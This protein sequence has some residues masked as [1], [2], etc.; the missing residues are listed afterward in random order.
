MI[1][2]MT[3]FARESA[4]TDRGVLTVELRSVN[5][6]Y[7]DCSFKL[8]EALRP[9]EPKL[10]EWMGKSLARGKLECFFR[11]QAHP[12]GTGELVVNAERLE[13][14]LEAADLVQRQLAGASPL[15][16]LEILKF[17][18]I[19]ETPEESD[20]ALQGE[21]CD[22][23]RVALK[24]LRK[25]R[26]REGEKLAALLL[27]RLAQVETEVG[28]ARRQLP[29]L[30]QQQRER[31]ISRIEE[32]GIEVDH[33]RLEQEL[34]HL[35][36][37]A[38]VDEE[39]DRLDAHVVEVRRVLEKGGP[40]GRRLDFLMQELNREANTLS[41]KSISY[42]TTQNAVE[43]KVLIEQMREQIQNIE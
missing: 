4:N 28:A 14:L 5:H 12:G 6:R 42:G 1:H 23:F 2:S 3:A 26:K 32:L 10:R 7:L 41:S 11:L 35:A 29:A 24:S 16:P 43:L 9:L 21:A 25:H 15:D 40:C 34:V 13:R 31:I 18:G 36:Q 8:P 38:D 27:E 19:C 33:N 20:E 30:R 17:P 39:L 22:L 37:K